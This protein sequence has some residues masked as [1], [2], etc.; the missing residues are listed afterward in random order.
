MALISE[1]RRYSLSLVD[2][3]FGGGAQDFAENGSWA[4]NNSMGQILMLAFI[5]SSYFT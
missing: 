3:C 2:G 4:V 1:V 5:F